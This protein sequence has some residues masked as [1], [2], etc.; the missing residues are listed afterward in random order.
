VQKLAISCGQY[1]VH[2]EVTATGQ[3]EAPRSNLRRIRRNSSKPL[4]SFAK[5]TEGSPRLYPR[6]SLFRRSSHFGYE[7]RK[8]WGMWRRRI[9]ISP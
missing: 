9:K 4:A 3:D 8:L 5:A 6:G 1:S 2:M 7:G